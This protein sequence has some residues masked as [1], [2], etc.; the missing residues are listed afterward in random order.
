MHCQSCGVENP[1]G[2]K[3]CHECGS[4]LRNRCPQCGNENPLSAKFCGECGAALLGKSKGKR[5]KTKNQDGLGSNVQRL[6][7]KERS[8][9][10][11]SRTLDTR[12]R[13]SRPDAAERR[14]LTVMFCDLVGSTTLSEQLDPEE[15]REVVQAYHAMCAE[16]VTRY[17]GFTA[18]HLG[19]GLLVYFGYPSAYEDEAARAVR[20]SL[21]ILAGLQFL[22]VQ[23][24]PAL[25][26]RLPHPIQARI[27]IHTGL[28][29]IGEIGSSEKRELL[30]LG[31]TPNLAARLQ[32]LAEPDT[33]VI[34]AATQRLV[35]GLFACQDLGSQELKGLTTPVA[36]H[37]VLGESGV[38]GRFEAAVQKGLTP[39][40]G[41]EEELGLLQR[42]WEQAKEGAGQVVLLGGE[43]GIGK[44]RLVQELKEHV[45]VAGAT[46][47]EFHCSPYHQNSALYPIIEHLQS[48]LQFSRDE[49]PVTK[50]GKLQ[51]ALV[52]YRFPQAD[53]V[54][55]LASLLS[56]PH[57][58]GYPPIT[59]SPQKQKEKTQAVLVAW[60][61]EEAEQRP[62]CTVW[63][64]LHW[65]DPSTLE[66][67]TLLLDQ[68]PTTRLL[69]LLTSRPEFTSPWGSRSYFTQLTL[70]RLGRAQVREM[71]RHVAG[72]ALRPSIL[73]QAQ[74][75]ERTESESDRESL[76]VRAEPV[77]AQTALSD[78]LIEAVATKTDGV[79]LFVEELTKSVVESAGA[80]HAAP[81]P[82]AIPATLQDSLMAR[83]DRLGPAKEIAQLG[84]TIGREFSYELLHAVANR[85]EGSLQRGLRRLVETELIYQ[86]GLPPQATYLFKHAL[87]QDTAYQSLLKSKRQQLHQQ[88][89]RV[90]EEQ[91][92]STRETQPE[93]LAHHYSEA[94]LAEQAIPYWQ[95]AG[96]RAVDRSAYAEAISH[97]SKGLALLKTLPETEK[98][99]SQELNLQTPLGLAFMATKNYAAAEVGLAY[100]R[101][102]ELC[103]QV[104]ETPQLATVLDGLWIFHLVR[105]ELQ[106]A[107]EAAKQLL[108][109]GLNTQEP[110]LIMEGQHGLGQI[111]YFMGEFATARKHMEQAIVHYDTLQTLSPLLH[112]PQDPGVMSR[113]YAAWSL[114]HLGYPAQALQRVHEAFA[115]AQ[116]LSHPFSIAFALNFA[117]TLHQFRKERQLAQAHLE[118][119][120]AFSSEHGFPQLAALG[121]FMQGAV[122]VARGQ[123]K[124]GLAQMHQGMDA[125]L[126]GGAELGHPTLLGGL[127]T[128][129]GAVGRIEE[130]LTLLTEAWTSL[131]KTNQHVYA[132]GLHLQRGTL[133]LKSGGHI[134][135]EA[136]ECF[137][138]ALEVARRQGAKSL[139]LQAA[140]SLARLW[141]KQGNLDAARTMLADVYNWFTEGFD[142]KDLQEAK[143]LLEELSH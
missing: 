105:G 34:S 137:C 106:T 77:E 96:Q 89:A 2:V 131:N 117:F 6:E 36:V 35:Q 120:I 90:L 75:S 59:V 62:V 46:C 81:L 56:L 61:V 1:E 73:R 85:D 33:V 109:L 112:P 102:R 8:P 52:R 82:L 122:L 26:A 20:T 143:A 92:P 50:L 57:P 119:L 29:V 58:E 28:V 113:G 93:L 142:T 88:I 74:D 18:Q 16:V 94:G 86:R 47:I 108:A 64:D 3:F 14:Q 97:L 110:T 140:I 63:E 53:T 101:A 60:L 121:T 69:V 72:Q 45:N 124:E 130:A 114:W 41:R 100:T 126:A 13:D 11:S 115:L 55:L 123:I 10:S 70:N 17:A 42:R 12:L 19:D 135:T 116:K 107:Y 127:A 49:A 141:Q 136:E 132:V 5:R 51:Q 87:I 118:K 129:Y 99:H 40:V 134:K 65:T 83:L 7:S 27:G 78:D 139:E 39:L 84:A 68:A 104:G 133:L 31:E 128:I 30:A 80:Q 32:G 54:P 44:S 25:K 9:A 23:L 79:P 98:R 76:P 91:F 138:Q 38:Q 15:Y 71:V 125:Y 66:V 48:L 4:A 103:R 21:E 67:L 22:N 43:P 95:K 37:Q 111:S 24:K